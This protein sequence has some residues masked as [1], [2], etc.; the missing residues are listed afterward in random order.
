MTWDNNKYVKLLLEREEGQ[1]DKYLIALRTTADYYGWTEEFP[2]WT[3]RTAFEVGGRKF[4]RHPGTRG[5]MF[6]EV[7]LRLRVSRSPVTSGWPRGKV[8]QFKVSRNCSLWDIAEVAH[9][10]QGDW[11][12][13]TCPYGERVSR[14][15]WEER[16][17]TKTPR[18]RGGLVSS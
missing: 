17:Q 5:E 9:F 16:Y 18:K 11:H 15:R 3:L 6:C 4:A 2:T 8:N 1:Q 13:L 12:W 14:A 10:T 7:G